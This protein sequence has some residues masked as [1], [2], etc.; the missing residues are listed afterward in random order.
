M[1]ATC[2][3]LREEILVHWIVRLVDIRVIERVEK[4]V[5]LHRGVLGD[6]EADEDFP[7][8]GAV[9]AVVEQCDIPLFLENRWMNRGE[10]KN[11]REWECMMHAVKTQMQSM[12]VDKNT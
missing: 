5:G 8:V 11:Q 4:I 12:L 6:V 7:L 1:D 9:G 2:Y 3:T 10:C